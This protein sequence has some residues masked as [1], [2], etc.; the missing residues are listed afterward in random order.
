MIHRVPD[1]RLIAFSL[2]CLGFGNAQAMSLSEALQRAARHD[3][4]V[5]SS[6]ATYDA[7]KEAGPQER[8]GLRPNVT[9]RGSGN[10]AYT[11]S[12]F[13]F[14]TAPGESY[15]G[16]T[17]SLEARQPLFRL[18]W[19]ARADRAN[20]QDAFAESGLNERKQ[21][22]LRRV[23]ERYFNVLLA[24]DE[25]EQS[26]AQ[27]R[28]IQQSLESTRQRYE[29]DLVP[30]TDL[31]EAQARH[32]LAQAQTLTAIH[33]LETAQDALDE[34]TGNGRV[35]LPVLADDVEFPALLPANPESWVRSATENSPLLAKAREQ[36]T[37]ATADTRSRW[38]AAMPVVDL[39]A[40]ASHSDS[41]KYTLG[42]LQDDARV[43]VEV[44]VPLFAGGMYAS[45]IREAEARQRAAEAELMRLTLEVER[46]V[47]Q[48]YR[49]V[50]A[51]YVEVK[52]FQQAQISSITAQ[53][54]TQNGYEAGT[55]TISD[56]LDAKSRV[57]QATRDLHRTRYNQ[58][59]NIVQL[60]QSAGVLSEN[61]F[62]IIDQLLRASNS[63]NQ[64]E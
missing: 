55:R 31:R 40:S 50:Q 34:T 27:A 45:R 28:T 1:M 49:N 4:A 26:E 44:T 3:P 12:E 39:V 33:A 13:A 17:A 51:G 47:K 37:I 20:A 38:S 15:P 5:A 53:T 25:V 58:L 57:A 6:L 63:S 19:L 35:K 24:Q 7:E 9:A 10:Y 29:V 14:G 2:L 30:G 48:L 62:T 54:A 42:Q 32:D 61:D 16:W 60:K 56:V 46:Q 11:E 64:S 18:D 22:L 36:L 52:A 43:G 59:L 8:A 21:Q 41:T 23:A